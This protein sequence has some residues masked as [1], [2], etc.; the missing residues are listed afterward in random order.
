MKPRRVSPES[1]TVSTYSSRSAGSS[2]V[3]SSSVNHRS[4]SRSASPSQPASRS[5][6]GSS[7]NSS[8]SSGRFASSFSH[9]P[10]TIARAPSAVRSAAGASNKRS[11]T[12]CTTVPR[13]AAALG[14]SG[15][16]SITRKRYSNG[17]RMKSPA[18]DGDSA[19]GRSA[20]TARTSPDGACGVFSMLLPMPQTLRPPTDNDPHTIDGRPPHT[21]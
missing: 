14:F 13:V 5:P 19:M 6:R 12:A 3:G 15:S 16:L 4:T 21:A 7:S 2:R 20:D 9:S 17:H 1:R 8:A 18:R 10:G 11:S